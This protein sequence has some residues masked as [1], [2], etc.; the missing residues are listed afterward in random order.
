MRACERV[1][2][3]AFLWVPEQKQVAFLS[4]RFPQVSRKGYE[5]P[6]TSDVLSMINSQ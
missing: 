6:V 5:Y 1:R 4:F 2:A 3:P